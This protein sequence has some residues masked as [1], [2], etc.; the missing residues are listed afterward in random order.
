METGGP[1]SWQVPHTARPAAH[2][3]LHHLSVPLEV[4]ILR[5]ADVAH[6]LVELHGLPGPEH[7]EAGV[8]AGLGG[9]EAG[10]PD[11]GVQPVLG[12]PGP[13]PV[14]SH[15]SLI[16]QTVGLRLEETPSQTALVL[17]D[18]PVGDQVGL[19]VLGTGRAPTQAALTFLRHST[20]TH[21]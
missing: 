10:S 13:V 11:T 6:V 8:E 21:P 7:G 1:L 19:L 5:G 4:E 20:V 16:V 15:V 14:T 2:I 17:E 18:R 12:G 9:V 3:E